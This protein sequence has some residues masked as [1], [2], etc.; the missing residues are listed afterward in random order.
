MRILPALLLLILTPTSYARTSGEPVILEAIVDYDGPQPELL[1]LGKNL[2][3]GAELDIAIVDTHIDELSCQPVGSHLRERDLLVTSFPM[4]IQAGSHLLV[5]KT[6]RKNA[7]GESWR[8]NSRQAV[9]HLTVG[10]VGPTGERGATGLRGETGLQG[11][12]GD[13]GL[14]G[15][16]GE[17]GLQGLQGDTG[18]QGPTGAQGP[19]G[20]P[21]SRGPAG[22][23]GPPGMPAFAGLSCPPGQFLTGFS[24]T[25]QLVCQAALL[26]SDAGSVAPPA[27]DYVPTSDAACF[28]FGNTDAEDLRGNS[29]FDRCVD[30]S[31]SSL[32][33]TLR[34]G[35]G[36][37]VYNASGII[38]K[39][40]TYAN[41]TS[42]STA[43]YHVLNHK[44]RIELD[45]GDYM[46]IAGRESTWSSGGCT[47]S[48][49]NGYGIVIY[50]AITYPNMSVRALIMPYSHGNLDSPRQ[51][52]AGW[53][54]SNEITLAS[55]GALNTCNAELVKD[56]VFYGSVEISVN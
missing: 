21:G 52:S 12:R 38:P 47:Y 45:N 54:K 18:S 48:L 49:G 2:C 56:S 35:Q 9:F 23:Q 39:Q 36:N 44:N 55:D 24:Q 10:S 53:S 27:P 11:L 7:S 1:I 50:S 31:G 17:I 22:E 26:A 13:T 6:G 29:W 37:P 46:I 25:G 5:I 34:D 4:L 8:S 33:I 32:T 3:N 42:D 19:Q 40:W 15:L 51:L 14:E 20:L 43:Q 16:R 41:L 28:S 30:Q